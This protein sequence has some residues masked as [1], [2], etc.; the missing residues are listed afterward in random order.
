[1]LT[2]NS[3]WRPDPTVGGVKVV[4]GVNYDCADFL[5]FSATCGRIT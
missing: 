3:L 5:E 2:L 1:M 4:Q